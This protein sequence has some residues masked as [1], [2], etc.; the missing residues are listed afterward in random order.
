MTI[1]EIKAAMLARIYALP[2]PFSFEKTLENADYGFTV[3]P[4]GELVRNTKASFGPT[5]YR[6]IYRLEDLELWELAL[7]LELLE[8]AVGK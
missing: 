6:E 2:L 3:L 8:A 4:S 1:I 7:C 5:D